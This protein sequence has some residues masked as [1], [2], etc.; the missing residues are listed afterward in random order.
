[1]K[2]LVIQ[3]FSLLFSQTNHSAMITSISKHRYPERVIATHLSFLLRACAV[4][5][6]L[7]VPER[8]RP[9]HNNGGSVCAH[10]DAHLSYTGTRRAPGAARRVQHHGKPIASCFRTGNRVEVLPHSSTTESQG[11]TR[12]PAFRWAELLLLLLK[13]E[14]GDVTCGLQITHKHCM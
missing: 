13:R 4:V 2:A 6:A 5:H 3:L 12:M 8:L 1:M 14:S 11:T 9:E 10:C 7:L